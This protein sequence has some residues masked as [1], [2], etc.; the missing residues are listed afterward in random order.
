MNASSVATLD[1]AMPSL[2]ADMDEGSVIEWLVGVGDRVERGQVVARV[3]TEKSDIDI[4]IWHP[5][6]VEEIIVPPNRTVA[7]GT[8][9]MRLRSDGDVDGDVEPSPP[10]PPAGEQDRDPGRPP[11]PVPSRSP[12]SEPDRTAPAPPPS[13]GGVVRASPLAR[14]LAAERGIALAD[15][16][17][18]GPGGAV[19]ARDLPPAGT[20]SAAP[21]SDQPEPP[22][23]P[24]RADRMRSMIASRMTRSNREIPHYRLERDVDL[25]PLL[26]YLAALNEDRPVAERIVPAAAFV[27]AVAAAAARHPELNGTW[28]DGAFRPG[29]GVN[30]SMAVSLRTGG[31]VTPTIPHA[32]QLSLEEMMEQVRTL[33]TEARSGSLRSQW[34]RDDSTITVTNLGERGA[35]LVHGLISPPEVALVGFG[36]VLER[37]WVVDGV[38]V[39]RPIVTVTLGADH[40]ATDGAVGS[41]F[42]ATLA[43]TLEEPDSR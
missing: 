27:R 30:L 40:R 37:P 17:G 39:P 7:V 33:T 35:D 38:V 2:G 8:V 20:V 42:L 6:I 18:S 28:T 25:E 31:L 41:R 10:H 12:S 43:R 29:D 24:D 23:R 4:E 26:R 36:R 11:S 1:Y 19:R 14:R 5:G 34:I 3:E 32:D 9:L 16:V 13:S 15:V 21:G 22:D